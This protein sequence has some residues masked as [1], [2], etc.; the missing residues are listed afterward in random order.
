LGTYEILLVL[1]ERGTYIGVEEKTGFA[2]GLLSCG[3][4]CSV[5]LGLSINQLNTL[6]F[7]DIFSLFKNYLNSV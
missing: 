1:D 7:I 6:S 4:T 2:L 3:L 5:V